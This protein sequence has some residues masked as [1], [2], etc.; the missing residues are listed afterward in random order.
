MVG[1]TK[2]W[3]KVEE[4]RLNKFLIEVWDEKKKKD[5]IYTYIHILCTLLIYKEALI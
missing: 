1:K 2:S 3:K 4:Y 5:V